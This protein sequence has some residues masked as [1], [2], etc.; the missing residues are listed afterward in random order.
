MTIDELLARES[1]RK[2]MAAYNIH[3]DRA[4]IEDFLQVFTEDALFEYQAPEPGGGFRN[5]GREAIRRWATGSNS[6]TKRPE[7]RIA[8]T[9]VRHNLTTSLIEMT[10]PDTAR[11]RTYWHVYTQIGP[12]HCGVYSDIYRK[13]GEDW[14]I[15]ERRIRLDWRAPNSLF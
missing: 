5:E 6:P 7:G 8:P 15:A 4:R 9:F 13:T 11:A 12:D 2:T 1:I 10:G 3:L 14:L